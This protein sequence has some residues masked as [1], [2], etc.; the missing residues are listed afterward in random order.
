M[1]YEAELDGLTIA[2]GPSRAGPST[3]I[4]PGSK[5]A[6]EALRIRMAG[7]HDPMV[8]VA[9][10]DISPLPTR[11]APSMATCSPHTAAV[12]TR[13]RPWRRKD[14]HGRALRQGTHAARRPRAH[15]H[16]RAGRPRRAV[17]GGL[18]TKFAIT[19]TLLSREMVETSVDGD[20]FAAHPIMIARMDQLAR[21]GSSS[22]RSRTPTGDLVVVDEAHRMSANWWV[23]NC[24]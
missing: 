10:S 2:S 3:P 7:S 14:H 12:S 8:A 4:P 20:P 9:T 23:A 24:G 5:L 16:R 11:F 18:E 19:A 22:K 13:R 1:L 15:A 17:A 21:N 6:T